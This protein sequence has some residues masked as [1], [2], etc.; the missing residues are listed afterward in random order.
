[1]IAEKTSGRSARTLPPEGTAE[2]CF[3]TNTTPTERNTPVPGLEH[4]DY[5]LAQVIEE[6]AR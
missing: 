2:K 6:L 3:D 5:W 1:M 4:V